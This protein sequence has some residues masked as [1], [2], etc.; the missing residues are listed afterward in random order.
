MNKQ[1]YAFIDSDGELLISDTTMLDRYSNHG[2]IFNDQT[3][4]FDTVEWYEGT[5]MHVHSSHDSPSDAIK[6]MNQLT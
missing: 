2:V 5:D 6:A 1:L 4:K 3:R